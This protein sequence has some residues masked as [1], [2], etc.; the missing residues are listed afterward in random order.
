MQGVWGKGFTGQKGKPTGTGGLVH[1]IDEW[2]VG[3]VMSVKNIRD[4]VEN[5][6][7]YARQQYCQE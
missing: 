5:I 1:C 6:L 4:N 2:M 7:E 3:K